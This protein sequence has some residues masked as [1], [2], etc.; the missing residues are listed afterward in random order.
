[1]LTYVRTT[2][3]IDDEL[4]REAKRRAAETGRTLSQLV[5]L[6]LR[7]ALRQ[8]PPSPFPPFRMPTF[9]G[10]DP[11]RHEAADLARALEDEDRARVRG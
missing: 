6:A 3:V 11:L 1:M 9:G 2:L 4:F 7:E 8:K 5:S 10:P